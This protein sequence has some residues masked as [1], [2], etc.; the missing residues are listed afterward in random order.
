[1]ANSQRGGRGSRSIFMRA[2]DKAETYL[3]WARTPPHRTHAAHT[4]HRVRGRGVQLQA[5]GNTQER[6]V[7]Q[8]M[9]NNP[10]THD[11]HIHSRA[12]RHVSLPT[13]ATVAYDT[14]E[15]LYQKYTASCTPCEHKQTPNN[16]TDVPITNNVSRPDLATSMLPQ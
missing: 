9:Q 8:K 2:R 12:H 15:G 13:A 5:Q 11:A 16:A 1:M 7:T 6:H 10:R 14:P 3:I 4:T